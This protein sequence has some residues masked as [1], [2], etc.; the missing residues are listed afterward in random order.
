M[1]DE[2][3]TSRSVC[4]IHSGWRSDS[5]DTYTCT[6]LRIDVRVA[7][8]AA[9]KATAAKLHLLTRCPSGQPRVA[10]PSPA[11]HRNAVVC[12]STLLWYRSRVAT[13]HKIV[14]LTRNDFLP[15]QYPSRRR[16][17]VIFIAGACE[18]LGLG[19]HCIHQAICYLDR[20][21]FQANVAPR[22]MIN[23]AAACVLISSKM[24]DRLDDEPPLISHILAYDAT[25]TLPLGRPH[26]CTPYLCL[27]LPQ[28]I[29]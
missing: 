11:S 4:G 19:R 20:V 18:G 7:I 9:A 12:E 15:P 17:L 23:F 14:A 10:R 28:A 27:Y 1:A 2:R 8:Q 26:A 21:C 22:H 24:Q 16:D 29:W 13:S 6:H 25:G 5:A 3:R